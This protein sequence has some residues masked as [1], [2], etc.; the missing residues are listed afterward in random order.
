LQRDALWHIEVEERNSRWGRN[1]FAAVAEKRRIESVLEIGAGTGTVLAVAKDLGYRVYGF[2]A[3]PHVRPLAS[4]R[5]DIDILGGYWTS[6]T[7]DDSVDLVLCISVLEHLTEPLSVLREIGEYCKVHGAA[8]FVSV[9]FV[10]E[11]DN[12]HWLLQ[13]SVNDPANPFYLSDVHITHF[14]R[15]GFELMAELAGASI[16]EYF[17]KGW[18]HSYWLE[19]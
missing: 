15:R 2:D 18:L 12:W 8:A 5:H 6:K 3:N 17:G 1:L 14:S 10:T 4:E 16:V 9:P 19:F 11:E 13:E 7:L